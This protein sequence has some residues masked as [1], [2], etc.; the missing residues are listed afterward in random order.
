MSDI[1]K[2]TGISRQA[3]Y[4]LFDSR[5]KLM[6]ETVHYVD[7]VKGLNERIRPFQQATTGIERLEAC[8]EIWGNYIPEIYGLAKAL[9][10]TRETDEAT[11]ATWNGCMSGLRDVCQKTIEALHNEGV[12]AS[13]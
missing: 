1:A 2:E 8:V 9:L 6:I 11:A 4:L 7:K 12:L 3:L 10:N 5:I 13:K